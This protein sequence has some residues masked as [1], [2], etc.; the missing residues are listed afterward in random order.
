MEFT[1]KFLAYFGSLV[2]S[3]APLFL[4]LSLIIAALAVVVGRQEKWSLGDSLYFGFITALTVGYGDMRPTH[5]RGKALAI[6][7]AVFGLITSGI[8]VA[9]AVEAAGHT[10]QQIHVQVR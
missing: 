6:V 5:G 4:G 10:A 2:V 7:I 9:V 1:I 8:M 3:G